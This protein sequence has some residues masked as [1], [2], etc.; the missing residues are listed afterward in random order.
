MRV[1]FTNAP[2][3]EVHVQI[4]TNLPVKVR[5]SD[6]EAASCWI[7]AMAIDRAESLDEDARN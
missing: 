7:I 6:N 1:W 5:V 3:P 4:G 2:Y